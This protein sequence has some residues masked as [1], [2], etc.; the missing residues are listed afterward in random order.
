MGRTNT[1]E[2]TS[3]ANDSPEWSYARC[4]YCGVR[5]P[6]ANDSRY[7]PQT[8]ISYDCLKRYLHPA[9]QLRTTNE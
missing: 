1:L 4:P 6:Y 2:R 3:L 7:K 8:C 9:K 5:Y